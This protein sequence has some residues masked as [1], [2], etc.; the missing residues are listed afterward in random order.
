MG[1]CPGSGWTIKAGMAIMG[2]CEWQS[3]RE[4]V[5]M[6]RKG[7][8]LKKKRRLEKKRAKRKEKLKEKHRKEQRPLHE[9]PLH[10]AYIS[11]DW[12]K[13]RYAL[14][15]VSRR[16]PEG[17]FV[18]CEFLVDC[19]G[20]GLRDCFGPKVFSVE[21]YGELVRREDRKAEAVA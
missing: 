7:S 5:M 17:G 12:K 11:A 16:H 10:E 19:D 13:T 2:I 3:L 15:L 20:F 9:F 1:I 8:E 4:E 21:A 14:V 6:S 18:T